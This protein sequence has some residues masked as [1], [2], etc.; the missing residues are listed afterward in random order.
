[1]MTL[2]QRPAT[3][4]DLGAVVLCDVCNGA[5]TVAAVSATTKP[6]GTRVERAVRIP[7]SRCRGAGTRP[8]HTDPM[9]APHLDVSLPVTGGS[10]RLNSASGG[11]ESLW[12]HI[13]D[14]DGRCAVF[15]EAIGQW[16]GAPVRLTPRE[17]RALSDLLRRYADTHKETDDR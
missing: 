6:D 8:A 7:C 5:R 13:R 9:A 11:L 2:D 16:R 15:N 12:I 1:M 3:T 14:E 10:V 4:L 17:A